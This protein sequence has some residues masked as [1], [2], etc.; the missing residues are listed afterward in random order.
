M[1]QNFSTNISSLL[2]GLSTT[3]MSSIYDDKDVYQAYIDL[4]GVLPQD[5]KLMCQ[6]HRIIIQGVRKKPC[7]REGI[8]TVPYGP[9]RKVILLP[10]LC[11]KKNI[12]TSLRDGVLLINIRKEN[13]HTFEIALDS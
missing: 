3:P 1:T 9:F 8:S 10:F 7:E 12:V 6:E 2:Q 4:P 11:E 5:V 13:K